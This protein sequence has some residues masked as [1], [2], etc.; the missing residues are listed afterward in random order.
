MENLLLVL[1]LKCAYTVTTMQSSS[2]K[3]IHAD[4]FSTWSII[5]TLKMHHLWKKRKKYNSFLE[6][7]ILSN[8]D[9]SI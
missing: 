6:E 3:K 5:K 2:L 7:H 1:F 9:T 4:T 8:P